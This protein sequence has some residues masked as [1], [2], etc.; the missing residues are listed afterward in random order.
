MIY[1]LGDFL[2]YMFAA[3]WTG[4]LLLGATPQE[5][6]PSLRPSGHVASFALVG[7]V[8]SA[9][10]PVVRIGRYLQDEL[11]LSR[12][13]ALRTA[14]TGNGTGL[15]FLAVC[16][17][18][19][20]LVLFRKN[21]QLS[22]GLTQLLFLALAA[23]SHAVSKQGLVGLLT[24]FLHFSAASIWIG[25][26]LA[27]GFLSRDAKNWQAF[28]RW[29]SPLA[30]FLFMLVLLSGMFLM[31]GT[32]PLGD[33]A[34]AWGMPYGQALLLKHILILPLLGYAFLNGTIVRRRLANEPA[35]DPRPSVRMEGVVILLVLLAS[36]TLSNTETPVAFEALPVVLTPALMLLSL[37]GLASIGLLVLTFQKRLPDLFGL[38]FGLSGAGLLY[39]AL[40]TL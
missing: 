22:I 26:V 17:I 13:D 32:V 7:L 18:A 33:Y 29:F 6:R 20:L 11:N 36:A 31:R 23:T 15:A 37:T 5:R 12:I 28:L 19:S 16:L 27:A 21:V 40:L 24:Q 25:I 30:R 10:L 38:L 1:I 4:Q 34:N 9:G 14:L 2:S 3:F 35:F 39:L 8:V